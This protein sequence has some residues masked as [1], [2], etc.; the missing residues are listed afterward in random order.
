MLIADREIP[1]SELPN[2][3]SKMFFD[4][5]EMVKAVADI[6]KGILALNAAL[7]SDLE[8]LLLEHGSDQKALYGF[9]VYY[10]GEIEYDSMI[11]PPRNREA[12]YPRAGRDV[13]DPIAR[14]RIKELVE[15]WIRS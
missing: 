5:D 4:E 13:A 12:G 10:D 9:N 11:N 3:E 8:Q 1:L 2:L 15:R 7:H 14:E 6:D